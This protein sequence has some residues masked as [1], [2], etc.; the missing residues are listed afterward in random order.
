MAQGHRTASKIIESKA[1]EVGGQ[2]AREVTF[3]VVD[4]DQLQLDPQARRTRIRAVF[5]H[6]PLVKEF[7]GTGWVSPA[8]LF[9]AYVSDERHFD[10]LTDDYE[11]LLARIRFAK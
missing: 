2:P 5:I 4:V 7:L 8:F 11:G 6:A 1:R 9:V 10:E 3:D